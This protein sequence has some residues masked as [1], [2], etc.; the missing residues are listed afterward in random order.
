[1]G[2]I[3]EAKCRT[4]VLS[5]IPRDKTREKKDRREHRLFSSWFQRSQNKR[6]KEMMLL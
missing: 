4:F 2:E 6:E 5:W 1:V 3:K